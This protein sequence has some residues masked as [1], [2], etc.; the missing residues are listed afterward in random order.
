[1]TLFEA[2][3]TEFS[4]AIMVNPP[5][6]PRDALRVLRCSWREI[7]ARRA[8]ATGEEAEALPVT[9][10]DGDADNAS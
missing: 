8:K 6:S 4:N 9:I 7:R 5:G 2:S 10:E 3:L 1:M